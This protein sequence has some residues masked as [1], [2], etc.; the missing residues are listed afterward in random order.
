MKIFYTDLMVA[1][2]ESFSP[3]AH[4]PREVVQSWQMLGIPL[5]LVAPEPVTVE[6][7]AMAH[8]RR[9]VEDV[10]ACRRA[11]GFG[12]R[13]AAVAASL[14]YTSG[15]MLTAAREAVRNGRVAVAPCSG[16]HHATYDNVQGFCTFNGLMVT[17]CVLR[18][19][20]LVNRVG[21]LDFDQHWGNGTDDI[22][23]QLSADWV[24][25]YSAGAEWDSPKQATRFLDAI[26]RLV[27]SMAD[28]GVIL[29]QAGADP[30]VDDPLGGWLTTEQLRE[31]DRLVFENVAT[32]GVPIAWN[33]AGGYQTPLR[34]VLDIHDNTMRECAAVF[35]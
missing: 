23:R 14:P 30:H 31:R 33:L 34:N 13:S 20:A 16:F 5:E 21:I 6:Q 3:S 15:S 26:P 8:D 27:E 9:F 12:N 35:G 28:C 11:N 7:F 10:L 25:H 18:F 4:K 32:L 2:S 22:L 29:Y 1:D 24:R 19:E 17:A